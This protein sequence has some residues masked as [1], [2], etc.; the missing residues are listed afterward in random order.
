MSYKHKVI[1]PMA[2]TLKG[3]FEQQGIDVI[4][5]EGRLID[6]H[7]LSVNNKQYY[8]KNIVIATGQHSNKLDIEG[9]SYAH[10][11]RDF[12]SL[13]HM[14]DSITFI[15]IGVI[16]IEFASIIIKSGVE[17]HMIHVDDE[18]EKLNEVAQAFSNQNS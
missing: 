1:D 10:D 17:T 3:L 7:D 9:K 13:D 18:P 8:A 4:G 16:S 2:N 12:L 5:G 11:S 14:P 15:G 6:E